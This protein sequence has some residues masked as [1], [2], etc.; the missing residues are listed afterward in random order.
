M[1]ATYKDE[2]GMLQIQDNLFWGP[3]FSSQAPYGR[4]RELTATSFSLASPCHDI[5]IHTGTHTHMLTHSHIITHYLNKILTKK[6]I[7]QIKII[8]RT[9][10]VYETL[11]QHICG[12][13]LWQ[14]IW[15]RHFEW[16]YLY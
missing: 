8:W 3:A 4:K 15:Q 6:K 5:S 10:N 12:P 7:K 13:R 11:P 16:W 2:A 9:G 14:N 1:W